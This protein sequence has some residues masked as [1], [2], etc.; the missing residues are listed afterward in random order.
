V[1]AASARLRALVLAGFAFISSVPSLVAQDANPGPPEGWIV[2]TDGGG[3]GGGELEF[4]DMPPGT[5]ITTGPAG[6]FYHPDTTA[7]GAFTVE[8]EVFLFDPGNRNEAFG[9][10]IGGQDLD[11]DGQV[12][13]Y[14]LIRRD[15]SALVKRRDGDGTTTLLGW[16]ENAAIVTWDEKGEEEHTA[17]NVLGARVAGG[18]LTFS[19][20]GEDVFSTSADGQHVDGI[21]GLRVNHGLNLHFSSLEVHSG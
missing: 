18:Q 7:S 8:A 12:Y 14:F 15:G 19:V 5:H 17:K 4:V 20:N 9:I 21:V 16:T 6:I 2:R 13:T 11:G 3:H 10:F 1:F